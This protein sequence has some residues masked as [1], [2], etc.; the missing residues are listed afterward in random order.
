MAQAVAKVESLSQGAPPPPRGKIRWHLWIPSF[1]IAGLMVYI[2][3]IAMNW[4]F[5][6]QSLINV[7]QER[8][9]RTV[10]I[11]RFSR[12]YFPPGCSAE[13]IQF[14]HRKHKEKQPLIT[15]RKLVLV[16]S[17]S[18]IFLLRERLL[19]VRIIN[20]HVIVPPNTPGQPNPVMPLTYS[21]SAPSIKIDRIVADGA[22]LDFLSSAGKKP[23]RLLI[24]KLRLDGIGDNLPMPYRTVISSQ[25]PPGK[26]RSTGVFG[27]WNPKDP[28]STPTQG[29]YTFENANLA[30][31][32]GISG[33]LFSSG[34]FKGTLRS[35]G[36]QGTANV[37]DFKVQDTSHQRQ[38]A[39][40]YRATVN[41]MS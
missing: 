24:D 16:T 3:V 19:L 10:T 39:V 20:M 7:L 23:Y 2:A 15:V 18:R 8:S 31:F 27:T 37:P 28:G 5:T 13:D 33:T 26:I 6:Q 25:M 32:G 35:I 22:I 36:V 4:P 30:A 14:L 41:G 34:N 17:Y 12:T 1:V 21:K 11:G 29:N 40:A 38:V 9:M